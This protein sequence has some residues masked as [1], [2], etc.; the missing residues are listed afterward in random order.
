MSDFS[1]SIKHFLYGSFFTLLAASFCFGQGKVDLELKVQPASEIVRGGETFSYVITVKNVGSATATDVILHHV[2]SQGIVLGV[3]AT[4]TCGMAK[5]SGQLPTPFQCELGDIK[6]GETVIINFALKIFDFGGDE[7]TE[8][9][10]KIPEMPYSPETV[11]SSD[12]NSAKSLLADV[13]VNALEAEENQEN[14]RSVISA[15]L[16]CSKNLPPRVKI[17]SPKEETVIILSAKK[18]TKVVFTI[19]AFDP[20]GTVEKV[21]V[22]TQQFHISVE[23]PENKYVINGKK[24]SIK[25]VEDNKPAFQK[26]FGGEAVKIGK[27]T[28]TFTLEN[29]RYGLNQVF[30]EVIDNGGRSSVISVNFMVKKQ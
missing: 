13:Y 3:P 17:I 5:D 19:Q 9:N 22:N 7:M 25:E 12:N 24:Y 26:Y 6:Q 11:S 10:V 1:A 23:Y 2:S 30:V 29:P 27:N 21:Q 14:N 18:A 15:K 20:D 28:Y 8:S 16:Q 4:G